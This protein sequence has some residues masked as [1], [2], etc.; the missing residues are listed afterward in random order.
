MLCQFLWLYN[1]DGLKNV[2]RSG[3]R[4]FVKCFL[5]L[6]R[7]I[8]GFPLIKQY[9][10]TNQL[11]RRDIKFVYRM[12]NCPNAIIRIFLSNA[13]DN[14]N[15]LIGYKIVYFRSDFSIDIFNCD[16][17]TSIKKSNRNV[18]SCEQRAQIQCLYNNNNCLIKSNI[19]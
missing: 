6:N 18:L 13:S 14:D 7:H 1:S 12:L 2:L 10:I 8:D 16:I 17:M 15:S 9:H 11:I 19:Q 5:Y 4:L 3:I